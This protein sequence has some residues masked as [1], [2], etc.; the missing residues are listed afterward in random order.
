MNKYNY[1]KQA[2]APE[3]AVPF[4]AEPAVPFPAGLIFLER[5]ITRESPGKLHVTDEEQLESNLA[6][7]GSACN[8]LP[9]SVPQRL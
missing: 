9:S 1:A 7:F 3:P 4:P 6:Q 8:V 5:I 2:H